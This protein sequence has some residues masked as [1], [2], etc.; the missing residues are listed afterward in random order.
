MKEISTGFPQERSH[1]CCS[2]VE[3]R[4]FSLFK[5][6][7]GQAQISQFSCLLISYI[8]GQLNARAA[9]R[10]SLLLDCFT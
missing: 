4:L 7:L 1:F 6:T 3:Y 5:E 8:P 2:A 9:Y 10:D